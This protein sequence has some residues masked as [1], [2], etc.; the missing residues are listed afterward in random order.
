MF[1]SL[2]LSERRETLLASHDATKNPEG[3]RTERKLYI[4]PIGEG[5]IKSRTVVLLKLK[6]VYYFV[7]YFPPERYLL[8]IKDKTVVFILK[9]LQRAHSTSIR[10]LKILPQIKYE[11]I[12]RKLLKFSKYSRASKVDILE[13]SALWVNV[14]AGFYRYS[15]SWS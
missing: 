6:Q 5:N 13:N 7:L 8:V 12:I 14:K 9:C 4:S 11:S 1:C 10:T 2:T 15:L 3:G